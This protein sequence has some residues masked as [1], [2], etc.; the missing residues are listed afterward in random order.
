MRLK[1]GAVL[2]DVTS[3]NIVGYATTTVVKKKQTAFSLQFTDVANGDQ[4]VRIDKLLDYTAKSSGAF[5][6]AGDQIWR[7]DIAKNTWVKYCYQKPTGGTA[8]WRRYDLSTGSAQYIDLTDDDV[9]QPGQTF[10]FYNGNTK[11]VTLT[12]SGAV[13]PFNGT[14]SYT[15]IK[16]K[17]QF[18]AYPW[19]VAFKVVDM[20]KY[21]TGK[22][23]G[24]FGAA[25]DQLWRWDV[26]KNT[27]VKY[28][29]QKPTGG[30][31]A[32]RR[33]DLSTGSAKYIDCT[34][35]DVVP[36]S[37]GFLFYNGNTND[38]TIEFTYPTP[39]S[40]D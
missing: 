27:W 6:A 14:T 15:I 35:D 32:W 39:V 9:V 20:E 3:A 24:A 10:L 17:Q 26:T 1:R 23:S 13:R 11:D 25:G 37:Q 28:C 38:V 36:A 30:T 19:P 4:P 12:L 40:A 31:A 5:G 2:A 7:W 22:S 18:I 29:Y 21:Y 16:K 33:Y 34:D 8:A